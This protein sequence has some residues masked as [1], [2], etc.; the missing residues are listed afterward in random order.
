MGIALPAISQTRSVQKK[1]GLSDSLKK[2]LDEN[3]SAENFNIEVFKHFDL[4]GQITSVYQHQSRLNAVYNGPVSLKKEG[5][6]QFL[7][8]T[9]LNFIFTFG[10]YGELLVSPE[11][12]L[13][14]G[15]G[16]GKGLGSYSN[17]MYGYPQDLPYILRAHYRYHIYGKKDGLFK[18]YQVTAG[19]YVIQEMFDMNPYASDPKKDFMNFS[20]TMLNA[21]DASATAYGYT[22]GIAQAL[23]FKHAAVYL[24]LNTENKEA[25]SNDTDWDLSKAYS[26]NLQYVKDFKLWGQS[27][28]IR[29]LG[30]YNRYQGGDFSNYQTDVVSHETQ[31]DST[32]HAVT[33]FG[34]G[35]DI[36][37]RLTDNSGFFWRYS[38]NDGL[39]EDFCYTQCHESINT[40]VLLKLKI[41]RRPKDKLGISASYNTISALQQHYLQDGGVGFMVGDGQLNYAPETAF[42]VFYAVNFF[43]HIYLSA[44]YQYILNVAY[45]AERGNAHFLG[46]RLNLVL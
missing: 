23:K 11:S 9:T 35:I 16:N 20:H 22:H 3:Y 33:K 34:G 41:I 42:E 40:G 39:N 5:D 15:I 8:T 37:Y 46:A 10:K 7:T 19:R 45:N 36:H 28:K 24:S 38:R 17:A 1:F 14:N 13:G 32:Q 27:G 31:F 43:N 29:L 4:G 30:F 2:M 25:G 21:W 26:I 12:Q 18:E 44:N 6:D